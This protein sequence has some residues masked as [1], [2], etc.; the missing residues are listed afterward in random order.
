MGVVVRALFPPTGTPF[1]MGPWGSGL[2]AWVRV[3]ARGGGP[4]DFAEPWRAGSARISGA[5]AAGSWTQGSSW[6]R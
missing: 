3:G 1:P 4:V 6:S 2:P 5:L